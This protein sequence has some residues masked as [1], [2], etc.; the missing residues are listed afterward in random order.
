MG[1]HRISQKNFSGVFFVLTPW[2]WQACWLRLCR[3][4]WKL[5]M[6]AGASMETFVVHL[7][8]VV[9]RKSDEVLLGDLRSWGTWTVCVSCAEVIS[10]VQPAIVAL[11][12]LLVILVI[13]VSRGS[14]GLTQAERTTML[15]VNWVHLRWL[16]WSALKMSRQQWPWALVSWWTRKGAWSSR[17]DTSQVW[18]LCVPW[19]SLIDMKSWKWRW[20]DLQWG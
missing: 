3:Q 11:K 2:P 4:R 14:R 17:I 16:S 13:L 7:Q 8:R 12:V 10:A 1:D 18:D 5:G 19:P 15:H 9:Q 6:G 20:G